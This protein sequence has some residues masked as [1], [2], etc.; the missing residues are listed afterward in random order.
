M[1]STF[2]YAFKRGISLLNRL[3]KKHGEALKKREEASHIVSLPSANPDGSKGYVNES[4]HD[5]VWSQTANVEPTV[6]Y[7]T[8][9]TPPANVGE[10]AEN[11]PEKDMN[12]IKGYNEKDYGN[13]I[14]KMAVILPRIHTLLGENTVES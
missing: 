5:Q 6:E 2:K 4:G 14:F 11:P 8:V 7:L 1:N 12:Y 9:E 10:E 3:Q 13:S